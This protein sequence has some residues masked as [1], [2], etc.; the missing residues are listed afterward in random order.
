MRKEAFMLSNVTSRQ[1]HLIAQ[2]ARVARDARDELLHGAPDEVVGDPHPVK[3]EFGR[4]D[5]FDILPADNPALKALRDAISGLDAA[6]RSELFA[7]MRIGQSDL[8]ASDWERVLAEAATFGD[9]IV[10]GILAD[11]IDLQGHLEK[12]LYELG[13]V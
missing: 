9:R 7:V 8:A 6:G 10:G 4:T 12:G 13:A 11:D 3:G 2:L 1:V 5:G